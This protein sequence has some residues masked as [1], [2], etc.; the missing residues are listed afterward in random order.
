MDRN[1]KIYEYAKEYLLSFEEISNE[2]LDAQLN[3][4]RT[5]IGG[6]NDMPELFHRMIGAF[7]TPQGKGNYI[8]NIDKLNPF[9]F[10][11]D[12]RK[13]LAKYDSWEGLFRVILA[14]DYTPPGKMDKDNPK[15]TWVQFCK[16]ILSIARFLS[17]YKDVNEFN[18]F[19]QSFYV[20]EYSRVALPLLL[21]KEIFGYGFAVACDFLKDA[22]YPEFIKPDTHVNY[23]AKELGIT[24]S[25]DNYQIFKDVI[26]Y[27]RSIG[28][29]PYEVD[30]L[31][32]LI[33]SGKF[34][35]FNIKVNTSREGFV[36]G[37]KKIGG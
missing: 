24:Q 31:F 33:G 2:M 26:V 23:I 22:G 35:L 6:L 19:V 21:E 13:V 14:S 34:Y 37:F 7:T 9:L 16:C 3:E 4:W 8:G 5:Q 17:T 1:R 20:N 11:F 15:N 30:K 32:Y 29:L 10:E 18:E 25:K 12:H 28:Q 27:C 36:R